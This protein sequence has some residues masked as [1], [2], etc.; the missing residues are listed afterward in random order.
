MLTAEQIEMRRTGVSA[1][2]ISAICG[3]SPY[4]GPG[5][6]W[7]DKLGMKPPF[8]G[9]LNTE[10]G[11]ELEEALVRWTGRRLGRRVHYSPS[12]TFRSHKD[13]IA[14]ATPDG[15]LG[16]EGAEWNGTPTRDKFEATLEVKSPSWRTADHWTHP[17]EQSDG[18]PKYYLVQAMWQAGVL[19]LPR[20]VVAGLIGGELWVYQIPFSPPLYQALLGRAKE[21]WGY[22]QRKEPP[23]FVPGQSTGW[24][25]DV[26]RSQEDEDLVKVP[27]DKLSDV[28]SAVET[29]I[30]SHDAKKTAEEN[31]E[32]AR[33]YLT[34][35][36]KGHSGLDL[37]GW[38]AT[39]KQDKGSKKTDW[40]AV[41]KK[42]LDELAAVVDAHTLD[43]WVAEATAVKPGARRFLLRKERE[44]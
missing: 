2:E 20:A 11:N 15:F 5:E 14:L 43:S 27:E 32:A 13:E 29:Y 21:F 22:V 26:Y 18:C 4:A 16:K 38:R 25:A 36:I 34:A 23:P 9:N 17:A 40:Q 1:S 35:L 3:L 10:R 7:A 33:G 41:A 6:V 31:M 44:K 28:I 42:A 19:E 12:E 39:W 30:C 37:P 8:E 24:I